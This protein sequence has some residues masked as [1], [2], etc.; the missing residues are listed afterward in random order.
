MGYKLVKM[1]ETKLEVTRGVFDPR[2]YKNQDK[3]HWARRRKSDWMA[4]TGKIHFV[5]E[6]TVASEE[7]EIEEKIEQ[8]RRDDIEEGDQ[9][10]MQK[11][12]EMPKEPVNVPVQ[13]T[14]RDS[15]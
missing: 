12:E 11:K 3:E 5:R 14:Q 9:K 13:V 2:E 15:N 4:A 6:R 8:K 10:E 7:R 1:P